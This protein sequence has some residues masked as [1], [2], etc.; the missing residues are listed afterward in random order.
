MSKTLDITNFTVLYIDDNQGNVRLLTRRLNNLGAECVVS[1]NPRRCMDLIREHKPN[2]ILLDLYMP[3]LSG[4][5]VLEKIRENKAFDT[6]PVWAFSANSDSE[7][8][9]KCR[10]VGFDGFIAKPIMRDDVQMLVSSFT[11]YKN[12]AL[13]NTVCY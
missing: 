3:G 7:S 5:E 8:R 1:T 13:A 4:F 12:P 9:K 11:N 2:V 10:E 6:I